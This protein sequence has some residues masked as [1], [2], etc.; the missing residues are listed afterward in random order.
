MKKISFYSLLIGFFLYS[1]LSFGQDENESTYSKF[2]LITY[3][4]IG[5]A[6]VEPLKIELSALQYI[7][8]VKISANTFPV[9]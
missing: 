2:S 4:T 8:L 3:G 1:N 6:K 5:F 9:L 7:E